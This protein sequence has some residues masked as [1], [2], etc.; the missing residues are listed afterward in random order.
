MALRGEDLDEDDRK[1]ILLCLH[2]AKTRTYNVIVTMKTKWSQMTMI[3]MLLM[4]MDKA[5]NQAQL[6]C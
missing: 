4:V 1:T 5:R 6:C 2:S 3:V